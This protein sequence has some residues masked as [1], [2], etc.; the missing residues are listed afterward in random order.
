MNLGYEVGEI[1][2]RDGC[3]GI[4]REH[5]SQICSLY[6]LYL[7]PECYKCEG[8]KIF[9]DTCNWDIR[10]DKCENRF[11]QRKLAKSKKKD[12]GVIY[13]T[14]SRNRYSDTIEGTFRKEIS[15]EDI[16]QEIEGPFGGH[17]EEFKENSFIY[18]KYTD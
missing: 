14:K 3:K 17:F 6:M 8:T 7:Y 1:C 4:M 13:Y 11:R 5:H 9:C 12:T 10:V 15:K 2:N 16:R 18:I